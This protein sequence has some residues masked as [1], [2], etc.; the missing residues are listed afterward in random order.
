MIKPT[1]K[2]RLI[3]TLTCEDNLIENRQL[4]PGHVLNPVLKLPGAKKHKPL[5]Q[6]ISSITAGKILDTMQY[7]KIWKSTS[8]TESTLNDVNCLSL[9]VTLYLQLGSKPK[10]IVIIIII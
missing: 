6:S 9:C 5:V 1:T 7:S 8:V 2:R 10:I 4:S 3:L